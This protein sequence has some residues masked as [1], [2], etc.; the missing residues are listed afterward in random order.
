M[1][2]KLYTIADRTFYQERLVFG[3]EVWMRDLVF[4]GKSVTAL[5]EG[6]LMGMLQDYGMTF[7][8]IILIEEG[9]TQAAKVMAGL[10]AVV[11]LRDWFNAHVHPCDLME[12][13]ND[14]FV[15]NPAINLWLLASAKNLSPSEAN[16][17]APIEL[18]VTG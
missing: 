9:S 1:D 8:A 13:V 5:S 11:E 6:E 15:E 4:R 7:L 3:S 17:V 18:V 16:K 12:Y 2:R 14:F 10:P